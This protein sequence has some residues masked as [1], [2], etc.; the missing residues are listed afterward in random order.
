MGNIHSAVVIA[1]LFRG[2]AILKYL[3]YANMNI[4]N[5]LNI[6][7]SDFTEIAMNEINTFTVICAMFLMGKIVYFAHSNL[8]A[9]ELHAR[10]WRACEVRMLGRRLLRVFEINNSAPSKTCNV[11]TQHATFF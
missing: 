11:L 5:T 4:S 9:R 6:W 2:N 10:I 3:S 7:M 8:A 1:Y